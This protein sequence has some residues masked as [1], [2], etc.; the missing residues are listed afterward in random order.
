MH[1]LL[2]QYQAAMLNKRDRASCGYKTA[3]IFSRRQ[4]NFT[5]TASVT[6]LA[7]SNN[8]LVLAT[9]NK[10]L[11]LI[12]L[13]TPNTPVEV[14]VMKETT[15]SRIQHVF[16]DPTGRHTLVSTLAQSGDL[17][18][19]SLLHVMAP[20]SASTSSPSL[21]PLSSAGRCARVRQVTQMKGSL[22]TAVGWNVWSGRGPLGCSG[23]ASSSTGPILLGTSVGDV[24]EMNLCADE[25]LFSRFE[26]YNKKLY[27]ISDCHG[28]CEIMYRRVAACG[29]TSIQRCCVLVATATRLYQ[30]V[31][32]L[33]ASVG[34]YDRSQ[35]AN[36]F[37]LTPGV[38]E[39]FHEIPS[40]WPMSRLSFFTPEGAKHALP[41][42]FA[43][44]TEPGVLYGELN[45]SCERVISDHATVQT[46]NPASDGTALSS[47]T[48]HQLIGDTFLISHS[49]PPTLSASSTASLPSIA[50]EDTAAAAVM[51]RTVALTQFHVVSVS[52]TRLTAV[53]T[54]SQLLVFEDNVN[55]ESYGAVVGLAR[56]PMSG[57]L[58]L[59]AERA[60]FRYT[61]A[62]ESR[63]VWQILVDKGMF[64]EARRCCQHN[65]E[66]FAKVLA[67][68]AEKCFDECRY[69]DS[70]EIFA[71]SDCRLE[72]VALRFIAAQLCQPLRIF[73]RKR[74]DSFSVLSDS[75]RRHS[76]VLVLL[77][78]VELFL[79]QL[80]SCSVGSD[81]FKHLQ[82]QLV[83]FIT[84][85]FSHDI[86]EQCKGPIYALMRSHGY[87]SMVAVLAS[88]LHDFDLLIQ[89]EL[90]EGKIN[91]VVSTLT[92]HPNPAL[93]YRYVGELMAAAPALTIDL[94]ISQAEQLSLQE[95]VP[96]L[97]LSDKSPLQGIEIVRFLEHC[98][99]VLKCSDAAVHNYLITL[100]VQHC[101]SDKLMN[102]LRSQ[103][104]ERSRVQYSITHVLRQCNELRPLAAVFV[105]SVAGRLEEAV[106]LALKHDMAVAIEIAKKSK[107]NEEMKKRL[108]LI[109]AEHLV[110]HANGVK[111]VIELVSQCPLL[112]IEDVLPFFDD[113]DTIDEF[114][115]AICHS[116]EAYNAQIASLRHEMD[117]VAQ[118]SDNLSA[119]TADLWRRCT[120][121]P[122]DARCQICHRPLLTDSAF[123]FPCNHSFHREC[124]LSELSQ[125]LDHSEREILIHWQSELSSL[126]QSDRRVSVDGAE[127]DDGSVNS[128][129]R[130]AQLRSNIDELVSSQCLF[131]G[132]YLI[133]D[134]DNILTNCSLV[135]EMK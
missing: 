48:D 47:S 89:Y 67:C 120:T 31:G 16:L 4:V 14:D 26:V 49:D 41:S 128:R 113:F 59:A 123:V 22:V 115:G 38:P 10:Q 126:P 135:D 5:P 87:S 73:L 25:K 56:D 52:E 88:K 129:A 92:S 94:L 70:A 90:K 104:M 64:A 13:N 81:S 66:V 29:Q 127:Y 117:E 107:A 96:Q 27:E 24:F 20:T 112:S 101:S 12:D 130:A 109:I 30:F 33:G 60:V 35:L 125:R 114:K 91:Q 116:L 131:C 55:N 71:E 86:R 36:V 50:S 63:N 118:A 77:W 2:E 17:S 134:L 54:F 93:V 45:F 53:N 106:A 83:C 99:L 78:I 100:Y 7:A 84:E 1:S 80:D 62:D 103:G 69:S 46:T 34:Q 68:H 111:S 21:F 97:L 85:D 19:A 9:A 18:A 6:H 121:I 42:H 44:M 39:Q 40:G 37:T 110:K 15:G 57:V 102:Y 43:W 82:N 95:L 76:L 58:W 51:T 65:S 105:L 132:D 8:Q 79:G 108:W 75:Q 32:E 23:S 98:G 11:L 122:A 72:E 119:E 3:P 124:L 74:L 61:V 133:R 28:I